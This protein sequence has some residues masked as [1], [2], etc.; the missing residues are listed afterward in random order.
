V[1]EL[2]VSKPELSSSSLNVGGGTLLGFATTRNSDQREPPVSYLFFTGEEL[3][4]SNLELECQTVE[5]AGQLRG[6]VQSRFPDDAGRQQRLSLIE[7]EP[8]RMV[9]MAHL[10]IAGS[11]RMT[12]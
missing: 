1:A 2:V 12:S 5:L 6:Q 8:Q 3:R 10:A 11:Q 4:D 9:R 7:K